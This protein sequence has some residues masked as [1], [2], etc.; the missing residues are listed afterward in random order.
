MSNKTKRCVANVPNPNSLSLEMNSHNPV[1]VHLTSKWTANGFGQLSNEDETC[2]ITTFETHTSEDC[3]QR[4]M[5]TE[6]HTQARAKPYKFERN[7]FNAKQS[8]Q[9]TISDC[10]NFK[11]DE[12]VASHTTNK[13]TTT[14][15][16]TSLKRCL[17]TSPK[18]TCVLPHERRFH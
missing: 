18:K 6:V 13:T 5:S 9:L 11:C 3:G 10:S 15:T 12:N 4:A 2:V 16:T 14:T 8:I 17:E 1:S 7:T